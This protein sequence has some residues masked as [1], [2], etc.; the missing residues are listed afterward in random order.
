MDNIKQ[1]QV[2][3]YTGDRAGK[4]RGLSDI[5]D[6]VVCGPD[7]LYR[8]APRLNLLI[9]GLWRVRMIEL[10]YQAGFCLEGKTARENAV[11]NVFKHNCDALRK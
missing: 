4:L 10:Q 11:K 8:C 9:L 1:V 5:I 6:G 3:L 2:Y 7:Y